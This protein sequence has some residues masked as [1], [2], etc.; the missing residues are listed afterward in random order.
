MYADRYAPRRLNRGSLGLS[1]AIVGGLVAAAMLSPTVIEH[2]TRDTPLKTY[3][4]DPAPPPPPPE[5]L[6]QPEA[7][8]KSQPTPLPR[9]TLVTT[10]KPPV[11]E[12]T[13][14][15]AQPSSPQ[16]GAG[17]GAGGGAVVEPVKPPPP[18]LTGIEID[19]RYAANFQPIYPPAEQR[20]GRDGAVTLRVL[21]GVD[22]RVV[23]AEQVMAT[24]EDFWRVTLRHALS[25]WRFKPAT[26]DGIPHEAWR[27][28]TVR[29]TLRGE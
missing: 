22:G 13:P 8:A 20:A 26:R 25:R 14:P 5:P 7:R 3:W 9:E 11:V 21:V 2:V 28:M 29:F 17:E 6:P 12:W 16:P 4:V 24:S 15:P 10:P 1:T 19:P 18:V 23:R 27:T